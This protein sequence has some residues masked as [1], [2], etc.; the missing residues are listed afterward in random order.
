VVE[1][2]DHCLQHL[3]LTEDLVVVVL[4][5][6]MLLVVLGQLVKEIVVLIRQVLYMQ[7]AVVV[8]KTLQVQLGLLLVVME[9]MEKFG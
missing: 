3:D 5:L 7:V 8:V 1:V 4:V 2:V 6:Q 9:E